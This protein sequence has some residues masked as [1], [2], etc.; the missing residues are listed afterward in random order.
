MFKWFTRKNDAFLTVCHL[1][2]M[3]KQQKKNDKQFLK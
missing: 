1:N 3:R 2:E